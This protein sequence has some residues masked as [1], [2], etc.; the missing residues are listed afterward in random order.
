MNQKKKLRKK[1]FQLRKKKYYEIDRKFFTPLIKLIKLKFKKKNFKFA[2]YYPSN[3][4]T[5]VLKILEDQYIK[6]QTI[7]LPIIGKKNNMNFF[8]WKKN[9]VLFVNKYG[10]LEPA[11]TIAKI[12]D[13]ILVP[14]LAF[15]KHKYRLGYGRGF[16]DRYL[17]KYLNKF[18][19]MLV[20]GVAFS[21]Q[22]H[23]KLPRH[24]N[25]VKLNFVLTEKG[26]IV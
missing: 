19:D 14:I 18:K 5:N 16:Y 20:V 3:F 25:D 17:N 13:I 26:I 21:F 6:N 4:E 9:Q 7:F 24:K 15:D 12:P 10:M 1:F 23:H 2:I 11:K 8:Q 22:K